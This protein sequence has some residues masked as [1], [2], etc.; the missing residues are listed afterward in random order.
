MEHYAWRPGFMP[1]SALVWGISPRI[2]INAMFSLRSCTVNGNSSLTS[3]QEIKQ[4]GFLRCV[5]RNSRGDELIWSP[6]LVC[7]TSLSLFMWEVQQLTFKV[8][9]QRRRELAAIVTLCKLFQPSY[10]HSIYLTSRADHKSEQF[11]RVTLSCF[12]YVG[13]VAWNGRVS[14][15][16][17]FGNDLEGIDRGIGKGQ[18]KLSCAL[19]N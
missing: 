7:P 12:Q 6:S 13:Y 10:I 3:F 18:V 11:V 9:R 16:C 1:L 14:D 19:T 8:W 2:C 5:I 17:S 4:N 15:G